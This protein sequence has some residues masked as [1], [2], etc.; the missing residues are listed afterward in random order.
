LDD[1]LLKANPKY[2][3]PV[4]PGDIINVPGSQFLDIYV[5]GQVKN[6]GAVRMKKG[7]DEVTLLRAIAQAGGFSDRARRGK[8][9]ITRSEDGTEKKIYVDVKDILGGSRKDF[10]LQAFD[11]VFVPESIL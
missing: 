1:L 10:V 6:P 7:S 2:N 3:I 4:F 9:L 5:F 8:V 11:V